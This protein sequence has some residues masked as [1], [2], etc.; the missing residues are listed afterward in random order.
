MRSNWLESRKSVEID[1]KVRHLTNMGYTLIIT[2]LN[3]VDKK[4]AETLKGTPSAW[5]LAVRETY[6]RLGLP[7]RPKKAH[8]G[9]PLLSGLNAV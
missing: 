1:I 8:S 7:R 2:E 9:G 6:Q 5:T 3:K 4:L